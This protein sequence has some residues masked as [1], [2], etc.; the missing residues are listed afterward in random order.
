MFRWAPIEYPSPGGR[1]PAQPQR[2]PLPSHGPQSESENPLQTVSAACTIRRVV[3]GE[4][5]LT[6]REQWSGTVLVFSERR[7]VELQVRIIALHCVAV[8]V[9]MSYRIASCRSGAVIEP[10]KPREKPRPR[11][12]TRDPFATSP[13]PTPTPDHPA[14]GP[15]SLD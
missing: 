13:H 2:F 8:Y 6:V 10:T 9:Y 15:P 4:R 7:G 12:R 11:S 1:A 14:Q 3:G 5:F